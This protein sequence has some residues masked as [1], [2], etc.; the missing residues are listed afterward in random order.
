M[1]FSTPDI[2]PTP[3]LPPAKGADESKTA[4]FRQAKRKRG[5]SSTLLTSGMDETKT[6]G[7]RLLGE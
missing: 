7:K 3:A 6:Q 2:K 1:C 5:Y 4:T